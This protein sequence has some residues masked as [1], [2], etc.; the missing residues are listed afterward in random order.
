MTHS[1]AVRQVRRS[2]S[3]VAGVVEAPG[4]DVEGGSFGHAYA[5]RG[6]LGNGAGHGPDAIIAGRGPLRGLVEVDL[7]VVVA[8]FAADRLRRDHLDVGDREVVAVAAAV[9]GLGDGVAV[10]FGRVE[11]LVGHQG[12]G[13]GLDLL[14]VGHP[15]AV[16]VL[17]QAVRHQ[18]VH[19]ELQLEPIWNAVGIRVDERWV[20]TQEHLLTVGDAV[21]IGVSRWA[22]A[23]GRRREAPARVGDGR[24]EALIHVLVF[25]VVVEAV[26]VAVGVEGA[27]VRREAVVRVVVQTVSIRIRR[28]PA[29]LRPRREVLDDEALQHIGRDQRGVVQG[30]QLDRG[31]V[32]QLLERALA[33]D[34]RDLLEEGFG[35]IVLHLDRVVG[36]A[37]CPKMSCWSASERL[38]MLAVF[39]SRTAWIRMSAMS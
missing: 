13:V 34:D 16:G 17:D 1:R 38:L 29:R 11:V 30:T 7:D 31:H 4:R 32:V 21:V 39:Q 5:R 25:E 8:L 3:E 2:R 27:G 28:R 6:E 24:V 12:V 35:H 18:R 15:I 20:G 37:H 33:M 19:P 26:L 23:S 10:A 14:H 36:G 22:V 9:L